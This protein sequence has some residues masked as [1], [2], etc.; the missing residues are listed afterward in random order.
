MSALTYTKPTRTSIDMTDPDQDNLPLASTI[1]NDM[2]TTALTAIPTLPN[3]A[4]DWSSATD[5]ASGGWIDHGDNSDDDD[6]SDDPAE[7][8]QFDRISGILS[9]LIQEANNAI[10]SSSLPANSTSTPMAAD[11][12]DDDDLMDDTSI[13]DGEGDNSFDWSASTL[14]DIFPEDIINFNNLDETSVRPT[15]PLP[16]QPRTSN[17]ITMMERT[18]STSSSTTTKVPRR[19][20]Q[21]PRPKKL[22]LDILHYHPPSTFHNRSSS[23]MSTSS[24]ASSSHTEFDDDS[25]FSPISSSLTTPMSRTISPLLFEKGLYTQLSRQ[26]SAVN[27]EVDLTSLCGRAVQNQQQQDSDIESEEEYMSHLQDN[28]TLTNGSLMASFERL[29]SSLAIVD[30]LSRDLANYRR[31]HPRHRNSTNMHPMTTASRNSDI[32]TVATLDP[33]SSTTPVDEPTPDS[34]N[35]I[36]YANQHYD[37]QSFSGGKWATILIVGPILYI[38]YLLMASLW[39]QMAISMGTSSNT[40]PFSL[41]L[42]TASATMFDDRHTFASL[43]SNLIATSTA[44]IGNGGGIIPP[45]AGLAVFL[46]FLAI[47]H[48][49]KDGTTMEQDDD[50]S[51]D[52]DYPPLMD[53]HSYNDQSKIIRR[54]SLPML[55]CSPSMSRR[56]SF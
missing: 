37:R 18:T 56:S 29:D 11:N 43:K 32:L 50:A 16:I 53:T 36:I 4:S 14:D 28:D 34:N 31:Q 7:Q 55:P 51:P 30:S 9:Q 12:D 54:S 6:D 1:D 2:T 22:S 17:S 26:G 23:I 47:L 44:A 35:N 20:S 39:E 27:N 10:N 5:T 33:S 24:S 38:P 15:S 48:L 42:S 21:L 41:L 49:L 46:L 3:L 52:N 13:T 19:R 40:T 8:E 25:L 45:C